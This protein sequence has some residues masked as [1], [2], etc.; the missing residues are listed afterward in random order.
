MKKSVLLLMIIFLIVFQVFPGRVEAGQIKN[1]SNNSYGS[2]GVFIGMDSDNIDKLLDYKEVVI[3]ASYYT[4][5]QIDYLHENGVKVYSYLN[6]GSIE[7]FRS[8]YN[9]FKDMALGSYDNWPNEKWVD[10]SNSKWKNYVMNVL[11]K[12]LKDKGIDGFFLDNLDVY[13]VYK[14]EKIFKG[15]LD[16]ING[17]NAKYNLPIIANGGYDFFTSAIEK[18]L[19]V[20]KLVYG[21]NTES[22]YTTVDF[23]NNKFLKNSAKER[24]YAVE[25]LK[26]LQSRGISIYII[27]YTKN[28]SLSKIINKYYNNLGFKYYISKNLDLN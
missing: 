26:D 3:D 10:V 8:Y 7:D 28:S 4:K 6:I 12:N 13:S 11:G 16:I 15:V 24:N 2:Y 17:L 27:E 21:V 23:D 22:V 18:N 20:K 5:D 9:K 1:S 25:Y 19:S 14:N